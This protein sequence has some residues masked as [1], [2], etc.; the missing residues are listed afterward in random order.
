MAASLPLAAKPMIRALGIR[1]S[2]SLIAAVATA[3]LPVAFL[4]GRYGT[5]IRRIYRGLRLM[6]Y[7]P[8][9]SI[10]SLIWIL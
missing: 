10:E 2:V 5:G 6:I 9:S 4:F 1:S 3:L 8:L 7:D